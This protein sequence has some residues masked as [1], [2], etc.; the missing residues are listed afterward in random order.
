MAY[1]NWGAFV[2]CNG[3]RRID[4]EDVGVFDMEQT[5]EVINDTS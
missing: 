2:F 1:S 5:E 4:K 3:K